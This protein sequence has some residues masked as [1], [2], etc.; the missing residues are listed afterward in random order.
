MAYNPFNIFRRNQKAI[1]AVLTVFIMI[2]F[3]LSSGVV[4]GDFFEWLPRWL[5]AKGKRGDV[6]CT[7][8]GTKIYDGD[9]TDPRGGLRLRRVMANR[10][11]SMAATQ[12]SSQ[13]EAFADEQR[14][15]LSPEGRQLMMPVEQGLQQRQFMLMAA[16]RDAAIRQEVIEAL[17][18]I[19]A[20]IRLGLIQLVNSP[21]LKGED[22]EVARAL[23]AALTIQQNRLGDHYFGNA[24]NA[25]TQDLISFILWQ[26]KADQ[27]GIRLTTEDIKELVKREFFGYFQSQQDV[28]VKQAMARTMSNFNMDACLQAIGEE[29]RVRL[30]QTTV[31]GDFAHG[32]RWDKTMG[33]FPAFGTPYEAFEFFREEASPTTYAVIP[34]PAANFVDRV[35]PPQENDPRVRDELK[36][37]YQQF[38]DDEPNPGKE[39]YGFKEPRKV[40]VEWF[41]VTGKEPYYT[42]LAEERLKVGEPLAKVGS[43]LNVPVFGSTPAAVLPALAPTAVKELLLE[44]E[45][46]KQVAEDHKSK[47]D[48]RWSRANG[49]FFLSEALGMLLDTSVV[50]PGNLAAAAGGFGGQLLGFGS[51]FGAVAVAG[52][53][54]IA[55]EI[56]DRA[57]AG[58][59]LVLG[60]VPSFGGFETLMAGEAAFR[61]MIP[62]P[63]PADAYRGSLMKDLVAQNARMLAL[64]NGLPPTSPNAIKGDIPA[65]IEEVNKLSDT[66]KA[67]DMAAARKYIE[68][69]VARRGLKVAGNEAPRGEFTLEED[70]ALAT[71][72]AAQRESLRPA[73]RAH[74]AQ[75]QRAYIPFGEHFFWKTTLNGRSPLSGTYVPGY[76]PNDRPLSEFELKDKPQYVVW[77]KA[78][79]QA[80]PRLENA[81]WEDVKLAWRRNKAR[82]LAKA[83]AEKLAGK[84]RAIGSPSE[85]TLIPRLADAA[86]DYRAAFTD[87]KASARAEAFLIRG[88]APLTTVGDPTAGK[89]RI[90][91]AFQPTLPGALMRFQVRPSENIRFPTNDFARALMDE[92]TKPLGTTFVQA[93]TP[94]D[95]Y[96]VLTVVKREE[97]K[98]T[99][100]KLEVTG[101]LARQAG[102][103]TVLRAFDTQS[104]RNAYQSITGLLKQE[105]KFEATDEQKKKLEK[106]EAIGGDS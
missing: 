95:T 80:K 16:G 21:T 40:R 74:Q 58:I 11:M 44:E 103:A 9:L 7:I 51:P 83:E 91:D 78:E 92:R 17:P 38:K 31:L 19:D 29:F 27:L 45:Y 46:N 85:Q 23:L 2:M 64:G 47:V 8:D 25:T 61:A 82:E 105:F 57:K 43:L 41:A 99:D 1:F 49:G 106:N 6:V 65:F 14:N 32:G 20:Q 62:K 30:A 84:I 18:G 60:A 68:E 56:R 86:D 59:P 53:G 75:L 3:T 98:E 54:P 4:G 34:V 39:G 101:A 36:K 24:P 77:R 81:A 102:G 70:P 87:P 28:A 37:L 88:V 90:I 10:F 22:K 33:G 26:K 12:T 76:Y 79:D 13:L 72:L 48:L 100:F 71:L 52:A 55:Y 66:G 73:A 69:F 35:E 5:G 104:R 93:D 89:E 67:K 94:K 50:R 63:I 42:Q 15:K 97:K 96:Y